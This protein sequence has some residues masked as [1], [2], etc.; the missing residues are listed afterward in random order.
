MKLGLLV[1][2]SHFY[3]EYS[4]CLGD[5]KSGVASQRSSLSAKTSTGLLAGASAA[6]STSHRLWSWKNTREFLKARFCALDAS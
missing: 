6:G 5:G 4:M 1:R 3:T 2:Y